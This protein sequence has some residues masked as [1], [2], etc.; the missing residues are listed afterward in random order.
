MEVNASIVR[1]MRMSKGWT[2]QHLADAC[3]VSLRTIQ[4]VE[5]L[6]TAS[7]ETVMGLCAVFEVDQKELSIIPAYDP[8]A[9]QPVKVKDFGLFLC[10]AGGGGF[11]AGIA[12]VL[13]YLYL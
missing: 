4:R 11:V 12:T 8:V 10:L 3:D 1:S 13:I 7:N 9:M 5:K 6:G 2:Q